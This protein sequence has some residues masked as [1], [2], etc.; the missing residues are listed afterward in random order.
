MGGYF[1]GPSPEA[2]HQTAVPY[3]HLSP[4]SGPA[5]LPAPFQISSDG[6]R[7]P[8]LPARHSPET[9]FA[10]VPPSV[11]SP[12]TSH[13]WQDSRTGEMMA[14]P[15]GYPR[16]SYPSASPQGYMGHRSSVPVT[17]GAA[18]APTE[19][20][21]GVHTPGR[22]SI[23]YIAVT[24]G[25]SDPPV[26][27]SY[28]PS[29]SVP[30]LRATPTFESVRQR[31]GSS[32]YIAPPAQDEGDESLDR[33][34]ST[35]S[36]MSIDARPLQEEQIKSDP[37]SR[38]ASEQPPS[39]KRS[40]KSTSGV[41]GGA[42]TQPA[43][44][45]RM[46]SISD[47]DSLRDTLAQVK[48]AIE[49]GSE[50]AV[51]GASASEKG[52]GPP[53]PPVEKPMTALARKRAA[54]AAQAAQAAAS[55]T[56]PS[57]V[58]KYE[59]STSGVASPS[60]MEPSPSA[61]RQALA[62]VDSSSP[63]G[64]ASSATAISAKPKLESRDSNKSTEPSDSPGRIASP[65]APLPS[66]V[67]KSTGKVKAIDPEEMERLAARDNG[68]KKRPSTS[69]ASGRTEG[70][71]TSKV[72]E[73]SLSSIPLPASLPRRPQV[74]N[75]DDF[76][77]NES[78]RPGSGAPEVSGFGPSSLPSPQ[79]ASGRE[80][81]AYQPQRV[82]DPGLV[83]QP[84]NRDQ[85][86]SL[87]EIIEERG[88]NRLRRTW[89]QNEQREGRD[90]R[91]GF[92]ETVVPTWGQRA[93][94]AS[95]ESTSGNHREQQQ[96]YTNG[97]SSRSRQVEENEVARHYNS[98]QEVGTHARGYSPIAPL[99]F[100]NNWAKSVLIG[101][102]G[103]RKGRI[104]DMGGGKGGDLQKWDKLQIDEMLLADIAE[105]SVQQAQNRYDKG[106]FGFHATFHAL[107]CFGEE[108]GDRIPR[109][110]L[111]PGFDTVSLQFCM[112]YGWQSLPKARLVLENVSKYL[113]K[114]G[115][116]IGTI[117]N[118]DELYRRRDTLLGQGE[119]ELTFGNSIYHVT[120]EQK[121]KRKMFGDKYNFFL[122]DAVDDV[123]EYVVDWGQ[124]ER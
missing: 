56:S 1:S 90:G 102:Y 53:A 109:S 24:P 63:I 20:P 119:D 9:R 40:R 2:I 30:D 84:L 25:L 70:P 75:R 74:V 61:K 111:E 36:R 100:F 26:D 77:S 5:A 64:S 80:P 43:A 123:P 68:S 94:N 117:P 27:R 105:V 110:L 21:R 19:S 91:D 83:R 121:A 55:S 97:S 81:L 93:F 14:S 29:A 76:A 86:I 72:K 104:M 103:K 39:K 35:G 118:P 62:G 89:R 51:V 99:K 65:A 96:G 88:A 92:W 85:L 54:K 17:P 115:M 44:K 101:T 67:T 13:T 47:G 82:T 15:T 34:S 11:M 107:D 16:A 50:S 7:V 45:K 32:G 33:R 31:T 8:T 69:S 60:A 78:T 79:A 12:P 114:G 59:A 106:R 87:H 38:R 10:A 124:F 22:R 42:S 6:F 71:V 46:N 37:S 95:S 18:E 58:I 3:T 49:G 73:T 48:G 108:L 23:S 66:A 112:H 4:H 113:R 98:R 57:A 28:F 122:A 116:F 52:A 120:F 41:D